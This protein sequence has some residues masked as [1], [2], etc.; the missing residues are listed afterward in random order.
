L[1]PQRLKPVSIATVSA[2]LKPCPYNAFRP[3]VQQ[4]LVTRLSIKKNPVALGHGRLEALRRVP[5]QNPDS[6]RR[7]CCKTSSV[8][9]RRLSP[10]PVPSGVARPPVRR[11]KKCLSPT[12]QCPLSL[13]KFFS[14][15]LSRNFPWSAHFF[16]VGRAIRDKPAFGEH[17]NRATRLRAV[18]TMVYS[19]CF[20]CYADTRKSRSFASLRMTARGGASMLFTYWR[21]AL[22]KGISPGCGFSR[23]RRPRLRRS[24]PC[25]RRTEPLR[26]GCAD[27]VS[28]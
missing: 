25:G 13:N 4:L 20:S 19:W 22:G 11:V 28:P 3:V 6:A 23:G 10:L 7:V 5:R 12:F 17:R 16:R 21:N 15:P 9:R 27:R 24:V 1:G 14:I 18:L 8:H 26:R 2:W